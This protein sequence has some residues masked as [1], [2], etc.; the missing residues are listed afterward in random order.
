MATL[1]LLETSVSVL[2]YFISVIIL[3]ATQNGMF[4]YISE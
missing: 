3:I 2:C 4:T 1:V